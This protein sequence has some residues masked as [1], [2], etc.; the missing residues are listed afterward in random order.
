MWV[1]WSVSLLFSLATESVCK[2]NP[3][4]MPTAT[5]I[6][7]F[8]LPSHSYYNIC[9]T[10]NAALPGAQADDTYGG[11]LWICERRISKICKK[12]KKCFKIWCFHKQIFFTIY[13]LSPKILCYL[14]N[15]YSH[16][17]ASRRQVTQTY[18][19]VIFAKLKD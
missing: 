15:L 6:S 8:P 7:L 16:K 19:N 3:R 9:Q 11:G 10:F 4:I 12:K 17:T 13:N 14:Q 18:V 1:L 2:C 5:P